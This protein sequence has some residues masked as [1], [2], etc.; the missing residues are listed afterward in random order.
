MKCVWRLPV[1]E[2]VSKSMRESRN[3]SRKSLK[4]QSSGFYRLCVVTHVC[5]PWVAATGTDLPTSD[6]FNLPGHWY[7]TAFS[8]K[9]CLMRG[10]NGLL[11]P[12]QCPHSS[13]PS[14]FLTPSLQFGLWIFL[15]DLCVE[16]L[17]LGSEPLRR[18]TQWKKVGL[19]AMC[20]CRGYW[21]LSPCCP[22]SRPGCCEVCCFLSH[23]FHMQC[24]C[25]TKHNCAKE[26][27]TVFRAVSQNKSS[28]LQVDDLDTYHK[29]RKIAQPDALEYDCVQ[30]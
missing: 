10:E 7:L 5:K 4:K 14:S 12:L 29:E 21:D 6:F 30:Q 25:R 17:I 26:P 22:S 8:R 2:W 28:F 18:R 16:G 24:C 13:L 20:P 9:G 15:N 23:V 3:H 19:L 27:Q 1:N 11:G